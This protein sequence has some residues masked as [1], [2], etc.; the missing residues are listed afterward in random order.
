MSHLDSAGRVLPSVEVPSAEK[1]RVYGD[2]S[3]LAF[4]SPRHQGMTVAEMRR[5]FEPAVELG[6]F[7]VFRFDDVPRGLFTWAFMNKAAA[8]KLVRGAPL[9]PEDWQSGQQLWIIDIMAPYRGLMA[10]MGRWIMV[11][12]NV[13]DKRFSFRRVGSDNRT[14]RIVNVDFRRKSLSKIQTADQFLGR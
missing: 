2:I 7:R 12:G 4:R 13:T 3:F 10:S 6:Q 11:P 9:E 5:Y 1:L 14:R 8:Q